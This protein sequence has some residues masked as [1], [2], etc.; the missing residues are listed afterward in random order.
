[1]LLAVDKLSI[2][3]QCEINKLDV[4]ELELKSYA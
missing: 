2:Y 4:Y 3:T 1:M